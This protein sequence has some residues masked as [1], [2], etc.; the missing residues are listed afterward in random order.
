MFRMRIALGL[1][2]VGAAGQ[3]CSEPDAS[4]SKAMNVW[5]WVLVIG[6]LARMEADQKGH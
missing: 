4:P 2:P 1:E 6:C 3:Q 5:T